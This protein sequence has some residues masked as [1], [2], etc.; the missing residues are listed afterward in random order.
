MG[1]YDFI[2]VHPR[3]IPARPSHIKKKDYLQEVHDLTSICQVY[4]FSSTYENY[5]IDPYGRL[6]KLKARY[7]DKHDTIIKNQ[8]YT[9]DETVFDV[10]DDFTGSISPNHLM[11]FVFQN[12]VVKRVSF[13]TQGDQSKM[14]K[15][16]RAACMK[17]RFHKKSRQYKKWDRV[18][19]KLSKVKR[20]YTRSHHPIYDEFH[21]FMSDGMA[22]L[23]VN[24]GRK[25]KTVT[26][27]QSMGDIINALKNNR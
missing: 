10:V 15:R 20:D 26:C 11:T 21:Q 3:A 17:A 25:S 22:M 18:H 1:S 27:H 23:Y 5:L 13:P 14:S 12:G 6:L 7:A 16:D 8:K 2:T 4:E 24:M 9:F 19:R